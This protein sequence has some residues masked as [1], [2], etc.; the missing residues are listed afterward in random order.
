VLTDFLGQAQA[1]ASTLATWCDTLTRRRQWLATRG[2]AWSAA[3]HWRIVSEQPGADL[4]TAVV[5]H[6][7]F[8][9]LWLA[10]LLAQHFGR[11]VFDSRPFDQALIDSEHPDIVINE[12]VE[13]YLPQV[14]Q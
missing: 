8:M 3:N 1:S 13:R 6:D 10:G 4:P 12:A 2:A 9:G 11:V 14:V 7:S 5:F